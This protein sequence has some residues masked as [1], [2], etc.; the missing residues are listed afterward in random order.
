MEE[1]QQGV[2]R[3]ETK[4]YFDHI[5]FQGLIRHPSGDAEKEVE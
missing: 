4:S 5:Y 1:I 2:A 3:D